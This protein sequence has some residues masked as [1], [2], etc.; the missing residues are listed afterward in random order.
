MCTS[1]GVL[2]HF[3]LFC[4]KF[5]LRVTNMRY[6]LL[7]VTDGST[8]GSERNACHFL[9]LTARNQFFRDNKCRILMFHNNSRKTGV[10]LH[11]CNKNATLNK[12]ACFPKSQKRQRGRDPAREP[13]R[14]LE[15]VPERESQREP[16]RATEILSNS[17]GLSRT[18]SDSL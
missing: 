6:E 1:Y 9:R 7:F 2:S 8:V 13:E 16:E 18:L 17:L 14:A 3:M 10:V 4:C 5:C 12:N 11:Y 15:R